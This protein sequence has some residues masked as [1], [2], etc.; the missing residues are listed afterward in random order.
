MAAREFI[1]SARPLIKTHLRLNKRKRMPLAGN[2][3]DG[4]GRRR[5]RPLA[6]PSTL[7]AKRQAASSSTKCN[8]RRKA[9]PASLHPL[10]LSSPQNFY[11]PFLPSF[12]CGHLS[13]KTSVHR[14]ILT[15]VRGR[16]GR[17]SISN[18][19][20]NASAEFGRMD[21]WSHFSGLQP[22]TTYLPITSSAFPYVGGT[23][24]PKCHLAWTWSE[25]RKSCGR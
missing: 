18:A 11:C 7:K 24:Q 10:S 5:P 2:V 13:Q 4:R 25:T 9:R 17:S 14:P 6:T 1:L 22:Q 3:V 20:D 15:L 16:V 8:R 21:A 12:E 19:E 23:N